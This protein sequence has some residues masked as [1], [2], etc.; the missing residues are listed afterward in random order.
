M[1][2]G[3]QY[4]KD[5]PKPF[6]ETMY[7]LARPAPGH[8]WRQIRQ[9]ILQ[10][11][12]P[13]KI[14]S[15]SHTAHYFNLNTNKYNMHFIFKTQISLSIFSEIKYVLNYESKSPMLSG[16]RYYN[17]LNYANILEQAA[18][19]WSIVEG[20]TP[21]EFEYFVA[22]LAYRQGFDVEIT[23]ISRDGGYDLLAT[24]EFD[25][26]LR[27][28][29]MEAKK[30]APQNKVPVKEIRALRGVVGIRQGTNGFLVTTSKLTRDAKAEAKVDGVV[31]F[32]EG[33]DLR[34]A[35]KAVQTG[36]SFKEYQGDASSH[37]Y[38][39]TTSVICARFKIG[40]YKIEIRMQTSL[41]LKI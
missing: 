40:L 30:W 15:Y 1:T 20:M 7:A 34:D 17:C 22:E 23:P 31:Q 6:S 39:N 3:S 25:G 28:I 41:I 19:D 35:V 26:K 14:A 38:L 37:I 5:L 13:Q 24:G 11:L 32:I 16:R 8:D 9:N 4:S 27:T 10:K 29:L 36:H 21:R 12:S 18:D 33:E 2:D